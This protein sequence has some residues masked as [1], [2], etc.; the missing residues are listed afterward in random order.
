MSPRVSGPKLD[1]WGGNANALERPSFYIRLFWSFLSCGTNL[2]PKFAGHVAKR[3]HI[4]SI[5][6]NHKR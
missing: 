4:G 6:L 2:F 1:S 3:W 5:T